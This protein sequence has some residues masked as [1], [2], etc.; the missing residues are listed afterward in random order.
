MFHVNG[1]H[2]ID[3]DE[4]PKYFMIEVYYSK[5]TTN[6]ALEKRVHVREVLWVRKKIK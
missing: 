5:V 6:V 2:V 3:T 4:K 1:E